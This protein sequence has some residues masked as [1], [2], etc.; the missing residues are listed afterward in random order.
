M[1]KGLFIINNDISS[2]GRNTVVTAANC[3]MKYD[4]IAPS[5]S[6]SHIA[7]IYMMV[8]RVDGCFC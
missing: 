4:S 3:F 5:S 6:I 7:G 2:T 8:S 1:D